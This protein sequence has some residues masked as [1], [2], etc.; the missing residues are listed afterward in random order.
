MIGTP[1]EID[2]FKWLSDKKQ[3]ALD[4]KKFQDFMGKLYG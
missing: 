3:R 2:L 1:K 4:M